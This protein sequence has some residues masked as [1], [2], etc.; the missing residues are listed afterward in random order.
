MGINKQYKLLWFVSEQPEKDILNVVFQCRKYP[1][2]SCR[3]LYVN[4][5]YMKK[6]SQTWWFSVDSTLQ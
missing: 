3:C 1:A 2:I 4:Y 5:M 6:I